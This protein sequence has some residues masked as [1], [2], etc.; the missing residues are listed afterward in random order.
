VEFA[1]SVV[2]C[3]AT[4][5]FVGEADEKATERGHR[6][7]FRFDVCSMRTDRGHDV[8]GGSRAGE[9]PMTLG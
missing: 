7:S 4:A 9:Q 5:E 8:P 2:E 3:A 6:D 1:P